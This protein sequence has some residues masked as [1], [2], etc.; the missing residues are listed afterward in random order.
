MD[1][2]DGDFKF[3]MREDWAKESD[4][5]SGYYGSLLDELP[6]TTEE[7]QQV[8][9]PLVQRILLLMHKRPQLAPSNGGQSG[10]QPFI[11]GITG[12][13][14]VGKSSVANTLKK[15]LLSQEKGL[16]VEVLSTDGFLFTNQK[17]LELGIMHR[18]GFPESFDYSAIVNFLI[19]IKTSS[20]KQIVPTYSHTTY[21]V[22][23]NNRIIEN[24]DIL[25][26]EGL[27]LLQS[28]PATVTRE[29]PAIKDFLDLCIFLNADEQDIE[30]WY[31]SRFINLCDDAKQNKSSFFNRYSELSE[32]EA[33]EEA[34]MIWNLINS[35][36]LKENIAPLKNMADVILFKGKDHSIWKLALKED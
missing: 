7:I 15:L 10:A 1:D 12:G 22:T 33:R 30:S 23:D 26:V 14:S 3:I 16:S 24:P 6:Q 25:I 32:D 2:L 5:T 35:P 9:H 34:K 36:N 4:V 31:V 13:V 28:D 17:L 29:E 20:E 27:N 18:K 21:D 8:Y 11:L 19:S